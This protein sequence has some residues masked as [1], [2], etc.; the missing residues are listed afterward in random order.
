MSY[1]RLSL[2]ALL[3]VLVFAPSAFAAPAGVTSG[4][5]AATATEPLLCPADNASPVELVRIL[6]PPDFLLC[7]CDNCRAHLYEDCSIS[8]DGYSIACVDWL[9][10]H[11]GK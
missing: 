2:L 3:A 7:T 10:L 1:R 9:Q 11:C 8:P 4:T 6:P 5:T